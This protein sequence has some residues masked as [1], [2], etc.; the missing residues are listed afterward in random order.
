MGM[1]KGQRHENSVGMNLSR[2]GGAQSDGSA[3]ACP[4]AHGR[5]GCSRP[6]PFANVWILLNKQLRS[7]GQD[8]AAHSEDKTLRVAGC[9]LLTAAVAF[10][11]A[12]NNLLSH[13]LLLSST[14]VNGI[15]MILMGKRCAEFGHIS[16]CLQ[17][18]EPQAASNKNLSCW[19]CGCLQVKP[20][21]GIILQDLFEPSENHRRGFL[22]WLY[23]S[24]H[25]SFNPSS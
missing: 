9:S 2:S 19:L 21:P 10:S 5:A 15:L 23:N 25:C 13:T 24:R 18:L 17:Y 20:C 16:L 14:A 12:T 7:A 11:G 6:G 4:S 8:E 22:L 1:Q 3:S